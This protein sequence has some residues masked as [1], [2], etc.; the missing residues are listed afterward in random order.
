MLLSIQLLSVY[1]SIFGSFLPHCCTDQLLLH[2]SA[3]FQPLSSFIVLLSAKASC[4][5]KTHINGLALKPS[6][7]G[8]NFFFSSFQLKIFRNKKITLHFQIMHFLLLCLLLSKSLNVFFYST[9]YCRLAP[10]VKYGCFA[11]H[12]YTNMLT[13]MTSH[14]LRL[15]FNISINRNAQPFNAVTQR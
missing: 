9:G 14:T 13:L 7:P 12:S 5:N 8:F 15:S 11:L 4:S 3:S 10:E 6:L 2:I 1:F